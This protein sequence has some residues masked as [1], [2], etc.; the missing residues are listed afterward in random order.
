MC[1]AIFFLPLADGK[2]VIAVTSVT[3]N[4]NKKTA[5]AGGR[6]I[7]YFL[8]R[9]SFLYFIKTTHWV[10]HLSLSALRMHTYMDMYPFRELTFSWTSLYSG[11]IAHYVRFCCCLLKYTRLY[12]SL[13][14]TNAFVPWTYS[15]LPC[16]I[17]LDHQE[18][19]I[20]SML[21]AI[22]EMSKDFTSYYPELWCQN[23]PTQKI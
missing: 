18:N 8:S 17:T 5:I 20:M 14:Y 4:A 12:F 1:S 6:T 22:T 11:K 21:T 2:F 15:Y 7:I 19:D 9:L 13:C 10:K 16:D 3:V 23:L